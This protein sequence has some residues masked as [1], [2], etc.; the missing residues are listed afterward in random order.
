M[1]TTTS[2]CCLHDRAEL[3]AFLG[4]NP[5]LNAY[6]LGD[7]DDFFWPST[8]WY[9]LRRAGELRQVA[10]VYAQPGL[11]V[12]LALD[13]GGEPS[14]GELVR[15]ITYLLP[16]RIFAHLSGDAAAALEPSYEAEPYGSHYKMLLC[17]DSLLAAAPTSDARTLSGADLPAIEALYAA[18][19]PGNWFDPR[20]LETGRYYGL[21]D[22]PD[23]I[24][25]AGIHVYSPRYRVAALGNITTHPD[26]RGRGLALRVTAALCRALRPEIDHIA[27][28]VSTEN[29][30]AISCYS[31]L[32]FKA[33]ASYAEVMLTALATPATGH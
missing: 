10:L 14:I 8:T 33:I 12:L 11:P 28:N 32:G 2:V 6:A 17:D 24:S 4:R 26:W 9:G 7:L 5:G 31:A 23:L 19:Y 20:M 15:R 29:R 30:A 3:E 27:L 25:I 22:G 16:R 13:S 18:S 1:D 21:F